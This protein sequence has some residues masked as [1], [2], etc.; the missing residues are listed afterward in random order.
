MFKEALTQTLEKLQKQVDAA[1]TANAET[2]KIGDAANQ[3]SRDALISV[4]RAFISFGQIVITE[5]PQPRTPNPGGLHWAAIIKATWQ[6]SGTTPAEHAVN[7][8]ALG[9]SLPKGEPSEKDFISMTNPK[10]FAGVIGPKDQAESQS[11]RTEE[12]LLVGDCHGF[13]AIESNEIYYF[14]GFMVYRDKVCQL[15]CVNDQVLFLGMGCRGRG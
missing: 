14:W 4:Q 13:P 8:V 11:R 3:I 6:N 1:Q 2:K 12:P 5:I 7:Y 9:K 15:F 10:G